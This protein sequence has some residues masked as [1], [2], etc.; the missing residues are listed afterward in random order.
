MTARL[1]VTRL[2]S[3]RGSETVIRNL[4]LVVAPGEFVLVT[5][6]NG[7]G[8][9][10]LLESVAGVI[11]PAAGE[12]RIDGAPTQRMTADQVARS[13]LSLIHQHRHLFSTMTVRDNVDLAGFAAGRRVELE[14]VGALLER[15]GIARLAD[16]AAGL[17]SGGEQRLVALARGLRSRP[18]VLLLDE[19]LA[20][21]A[22]EVRD[23]LLVELQRIAHTGTAVV[24]VEHDIDRVRPFADRTLTLQRGEIVAAAGTGARA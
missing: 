7:C 16:T 10:T 22:G 20:A 5:G 13:G 1:A 6:T 11:R 21:L 24:I 4:S 17:L 12:V 8:K 2:W 15:F 18:R 19:P 9:S 14:P 23:R 3:R